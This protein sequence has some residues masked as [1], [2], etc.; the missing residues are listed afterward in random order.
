MAETDWRRAAPAF[1]EPALG[2]SIA[3]RDALRAIAAR[4]DTSVG[5]V[6]IAWTLAWPGVT[7]AIV[8]ARRPDQVDG[9][10][11]GSQIELSADELAE[12]AQAIDDTGAGSGPTTPAS[13]H[14]LFA[15]G[16]PS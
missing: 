4:H 16:N 2:R 15:G 3:L 5:A 8:G 13:R 1:N 12:I 11:A 9:W 7:G 10:I 6:A 14:G